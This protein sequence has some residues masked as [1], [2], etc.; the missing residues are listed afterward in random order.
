MRTESAN[1][2]EVE[3]KWFVVDATDLVLGRM[4]SKI[5]GILRG[6][7]KPIFT[8]NADTGDFVVVINAAKIKVTGR[9]ADQKEYFHHTGYL[10]GIKSIT[11]GNLLQK[12]PEDL[13]R[14]AV[15]GMLPKGPLGR[16]EF[17]KLKVYS[18][19]DHPHAAQQPQVLKLS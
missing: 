5:A 17:T 6:K 4:A 13:I 12:C 9:K 18:G 15:K 14:I 1:A 2:H 7:H 11:A 19:P 10:G 8:P 3:R 16:Q